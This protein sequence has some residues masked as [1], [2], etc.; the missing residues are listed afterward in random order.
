MRVAGKGRVQN[1]E[2]FMAESPAA[3][4]IDGQKLQVL[5]LRAKKEVEEGLL[6]GCQ[7]AVA[8]CGRL[9]A[10]EAFGDATKDS[11]FPVFSCTKAITSAAA[12]QLMEAGRLDVR[13]K[14]A[15]LV[16]EFARN[17]KQDISV[18]QLF[19]HTSGFPHARFRA[20]LWLDR[21]ARLKRFGDWKLNWEPGS[22]FEYHPTSSM[23][24]IAEIIERLSGETF[25]DYVRQHIALPLGLTDLW[26]GCPDEQHH[27]IQP[28]VHVGEALTADDY[29]ALGMPVPPETEVTEEALSAFNQP[30]VRRV[31]V[32]GGGGIMSA[33]ELAL[34]YQALLHGRAEDGTSLWSKKTLAEATAPVCQLP[35]M[36][37]IPVNR[38]L[39]VVVAGD[40]KRNFRGF[41]HTNTEAAFGHGGAGGQ[42]AWADPLTGISFGYCTN[43]HDRNAV[44]QGR[45][46]VSLSNRAADILAD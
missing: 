11:L 23:W 45:R 30:E 31:P 24:V 8:R 38:A 20:T 26:V 7:V 41:G 33:A 29:A 25:S 17:G 4:G 18:E 2:K 39:G 13:V 12:W 1:P 16:P 21:E 34:F 3:A 37:G 15:E 19:L 10:F 6:P 36:L 14:V 44:R 9:V 28:V 35:D 27:R 42:V 46:G 22:R 5:L 32:P 40:A 43:G